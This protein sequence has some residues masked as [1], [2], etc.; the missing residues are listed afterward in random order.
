MTRKITASLLS[1]P[2]RSALRGFSLVEMI[3]VTFLLALAMLG[4]LAV[5]DAS[6]RI[7]KSETEVADAQ[8]S[9]RYGVY[10]MTRVIRMAGSGGL[11]VTQA[12][13]NQGDPELVGITPPGISY[14]NV[15]SGV[16]I[17]RM[18]SATAVDVRP[19][20]DMI[21]I[22]GVILSPLVGFA[23][24]SGCGACI[25]DSP[26]TAPTVAGNFFVGQHVN[27]DAANR[28]Q[29]AA[30]DAYTAGTIAANPR[31]VLVSANDDIHGGCSDAAG[32]PLYPQ[33][34]YNVG[35]IEGATT[36]V[37][38]NT[39]GTVR[40]AAAFGGPTGVTQ[41]NSEIPAAAGAPALAITNLKRAGI[42]DDIIFFIDN[43]DARHPALA[44]GIRRGAAFDIV[45]IADDVEDM[46]IAYGVDT[47]T[48]GGG[49]PDGAVTRIG[50]TN[51]P[52]DIDPNVS[53]V[54]DTATTGDE[55][56]P[57]AASETPLVATDFQSS[58]GPFT[59]AGFPPPAHCPRLHAVMISLI[60]K[61]RDPDP[62]Y[63][64]PNRLGIRTMNVQ[65]D[66]ATS[67]PITATYPAPNPNPQYRRRV[68]TLK[69]NLRNY[70]NQG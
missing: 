13:L 19:G 29:F 47:R 58:P 38:S 35:L 1:L 8:S 44:Q 43:S 67:I 59:H 5:F 15:P 64:A 50:P 20:T 68:Q 24:Q 52:L 60:A 30:I 26:L 45:L 70:S 16:T 22:R 55:W 27:H 62:T 53:T 14:D 39:F 33:S 63:R 48:P 41:F 11:F 32:N 31:F 6:A 9:V 12:V 57:N 17:A 36:L 66:V 56:S 42:M 37:A 3:V 69:I 2:R 10:Q 51:P 54:A 65:V 34:P 46:Q 23:G 18:G 21:E 61:S 4:L 7:N 49:P 40:F 28:P 25:G